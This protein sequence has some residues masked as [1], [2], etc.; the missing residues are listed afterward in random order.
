MLNTYSP[1]GSGFEVILVEDFPYGVNVT[2]WVF[3][4]RLVLIDVFDD[5]RLV[6]AELTINLRF[7][8]SVVSLCST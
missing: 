5:H 1:G 2:C 7:F 3:E 6:D 4:V 8:F